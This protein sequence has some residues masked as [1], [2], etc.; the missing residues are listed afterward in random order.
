[1]PSVL[2][3]SVF[4]AECHNKVQYAECRYAE[5]HSAKCHYV[6]C[7]GARFDGSGIKENWKEPGKISERRHYTRHND[8]QHNDI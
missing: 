1:M 3:L 4:Y 5:C 2:M 8:T 6:E 7:R